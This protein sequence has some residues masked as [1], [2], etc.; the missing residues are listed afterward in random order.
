MTYEQERRRWGAINADQALIDQAGPGFYLFA[1]VGALGA[2]AIVAVRTG[3][4]VSGRT[5]ETTPLP[6]A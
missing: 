6:L 2:I 3:R 5:S 1:A 4:T